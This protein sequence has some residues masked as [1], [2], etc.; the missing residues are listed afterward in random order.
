[1]ALAPAGENSLFNAALA[2][3]FAADGQRQLRSEMAMVTN[4][5]L[6]ARQVDFGD[7]EAVRT[8]VEMTHDYL[9]LGLENLASGDLRAAVDNLRDTHLKLLFRLGV[10]LTIDLRTRAEALVRRLGLDPRRTREI[11]Y[12]DTPYRE[13]LAGLLVR[14]P[15]FYAGL[16]GAA[17]VQMRDFRAMRDL[18]LGYAML[19][20]IAAAVELFKSLFRIDIGSPGFRAGVASR[21]IRLSQILLT[22]FARESLE[23][24]FVFE[25]IEASR[26]LELHR[27][28]MT[29]GRPARL[30]D[31]FRSD[32]EAL[33]EGRL[34]EEIRRRS[35]AFINSCL[36]IIEDEFADLDP[37]QRIDPRFIQ[38]VLLKRG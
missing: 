10:S 13:A 37:H 31:G 30:S 21:E 1:M 19:E 18:H 7:P 23:Q 32:V 36:N 16:D 20:E 9:N 25:P 11:S 15:R 6:V 33:M 29:D 22:A 34:E 2:A 3:G 28:I 38:S 14:Q 12:L 35:A 24:R 26:L 27:R 4:Q 5:V 8:A 17:S